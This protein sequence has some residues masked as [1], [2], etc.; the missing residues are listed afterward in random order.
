MAVRC[1]HHPLPLPLSTVKCLI[2][3][4]C[5]FTWD[6][7][8]SDTLRA[9]TRGHYRSDS[10][11][12]PWKRQTPCI[13]DVALTRLRLGHTTL[14]AHLHRL[15]LTPDPPRP[16]TASHLQPPM[17]VYRFRNKQLEKYVKAME[18]QRV[19]AGSVSGGSGSGSGSRELP[20]S[21]T[22]NFSKRAQTISMEMAK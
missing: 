2:S 1:N 4:V 20:G 12:H 18:N 22:S 21:L 3:Q 11:P 7:S 5:R 14:M 15:H 16:I 19:K 10:S 9:P 13:L 6:T 8:L 17:F